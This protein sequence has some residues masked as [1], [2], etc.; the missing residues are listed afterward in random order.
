MDSWDA[1]FAIIGIIVGFFSFIFP[2][3][4]ICLYDSKCNEI[5][6]KQQE[7][8]IENYIKNNKNE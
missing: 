1:E 4:E 6:G 5:S 7:I 3:I 8:F 2:L